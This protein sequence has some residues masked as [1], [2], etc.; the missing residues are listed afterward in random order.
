MKYITVSPTLEKAV[1]DKMSATMALC[2]THYSTRSIPVPTLRFRQLGRVAG[3]CS[4]NFYSNTGEIVIN[5]DFF[6]NYY[7]D[8]L[9]DTVP[10][11]VAHHVS[12]FI[13]GRKGYNH[14]HLWKD[15]MRVV[16]V[17]AA[18]RCHEYSLDG[19]KVR[20]V[21]RPYKY[22]CGCTTNGHQ[23]TQYKHNQH[24]LSLQRGRCGLKCGKCCRFIVYEGFTQN[25]IFIPVAKRQ[26]P[27]TV[28]IPAPR[29]LVP[30]K[31]TPITT[32][33][34]EPTITITEQ[35]P[36]FKYVPRFVNG[37]LVNVKVPITA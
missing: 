14:S 5:P 27:P 12:A 15:V 19:V 1:R 2:Q 11:E 4:F 16:G 34:P 18:E 22:S 36:A 20:N 26:T 28:V 35:V 3:R 6:K 29:L 33:K 8:M 9:H 10:H 21:Q 17:K 25:G 24:Q 31:I 30:V 7:D 32:F 23:L 37:V 13:Y